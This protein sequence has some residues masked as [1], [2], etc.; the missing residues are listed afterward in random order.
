MA[1]IGIKLF[2]SERKI[3]YVSNQKEVIIELIR[4]QTVCCATYIHKLK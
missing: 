4:K 2:K 3:F 1:R